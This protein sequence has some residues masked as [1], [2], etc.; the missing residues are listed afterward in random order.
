MKD[1]KIVL[2][3]HKHYSTTHSYLY[4]SLC[5]TFQRYGYEVYWFDDS[6]YP[7]VSEF[8]Y[9]NSVFVIDNQGRKDINCPVIESGIYFSWDRF[10]SLE[11]YLGK[12]KRLINFRCPEYKAPKPD[13]K[14]FVEIEKGIIY[15]RTPEDPYEVMYFYL[16]TN[17]WPEEMEYEDIS[18]C[19]DNV[20]NFVG[21]IHAPRPNSEPLHQQFI[22]IIKSKGIKFNHYDAEISHNNPNYK[23]VDEQTNIKLMQKSIFVPDFRPQEQKDTHYVACRIMKAI[24]YGCLVVSDSSYVKDFIDKELLCADT[25]QEIFDLGM[26]NQYNKELIRYLMDVVKREHTYLNRVR[27]FITIIENEKI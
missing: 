20:Y 22:E 2:W 7:H 5:R 15:D 18:I 24:S 4:V 8:N 6:D 21:T 27:G 25:A 14:R 10:V 19:R 1:Y 12:V 16:A 26:K 11:K 3:G 9:E 13:G 23:P 17:L